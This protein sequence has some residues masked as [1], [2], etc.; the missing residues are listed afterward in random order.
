M[1]YCFDD[2]KNAYRAEWRAYIRHDFVRQLGAGTLAEDAFRYYLQQDY[3]FIQY[4][5]RAYALAIYKSRHIADLR[6]AFDALKTL[7]DTELTLHI[8]YCRQWGITEQDL[9]EL[10]EAKATIAYTRYVLDTGNRGDLLDMRVAT[11][12]CLIGYGEIAHFLN[13]APATRRAGNPY[14]AWIQMY[15]SDAFQT[16]M[17]REVEWLDER[18]ADVTEQRFQELAEIFRDA[19]RLEI[20]F[21]QMGLGQSANSR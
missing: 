9:A 2:L 7:I 20:D 21:W 13:D 5:A 19:T 12:P 6:H 15:E 8:D 4:F 14:D 10:P 1:G 16:V 17:H 3:L 18:L 11:A